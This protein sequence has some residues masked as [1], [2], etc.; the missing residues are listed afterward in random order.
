MELTPANR[1]RIKTHVALDPLTS[2]SRVY[3]RG[4]IVVWRAVKQLATDHTTCQLDVN[5]RQLTV[6]SDDEHV[7][8]PEVLNSAR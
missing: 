6:P 4:Q 3:L 2:R 7:R 1:S 5:H 8:R